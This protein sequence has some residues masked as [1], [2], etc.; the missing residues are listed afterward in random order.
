MRPFSLLRRDLVGHLSTKQTIRSFGSLAGRVP[1]KGVRE[2]PAVPDRLK[3]AV[4]YFGNQSTNVVAEDTPYV[5]QD[6]RQNLVREVLGMHQNLKSASKLDRLKSALDAAQHTEANSEKWKE[7]YVFLRTTEQCGELVQDPTDVFPRGSALWIDLT[8]CEEARL[9]HICQ[10]PNGMLIF[11]AFSFEEYLNHYFQ[12]L[13]IFDSVWFPVPRMGSKYED[14]CNMEFPVCAT[15][16]IANMCTLATV[17]YDANQFGISI[18]LLQ[19]T[20]K[21]LTYP[22]MIRISQKAPFSGETIEG[23]HPALQRTFNTT[24][25]EVKRIATRKELAE[26]LA[27]R[28]KI[29]QIAQLELQLLI[30]EFNEIQQVY[31]RTVATPKWKQLLGKSETMTQIDIVLKEKD[32]TLSRAIAERLSGWSFLEEFQSDIHM[33][34]GTEKPSIDSKAMLL[35]DGEVD[36]AMFRA[37]AINNGPSLKELLDYDA[38]L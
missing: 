18:N 38:P 17:A 11:P 12:R 33:E 8:E 30:F 14:F 7:V 13:K 6:K 16:K 15:G 36:G 28:P 31:V 26:A 9:P 2:Q 27:S 23:F 24:K 25:L 22:E 10:L 32:S 35:Y 4:S 34:F 37:I 21:F 20:T 3:D 19:N 1:S 29:P 5:P